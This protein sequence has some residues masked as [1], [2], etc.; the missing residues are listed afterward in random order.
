LN[1]KGFIVGKGFKRC[2][3][4][5]AFVPAEGSDYQKAEAL[6]ILILVTLQKPQTM[7]IIQISQHR[8]AGGEIA[9]GIQMLFQIWQQPQI[10]DIGQKRDGGLGF[11]RIGIRK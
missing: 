6:I 1:Q 8:E 5:F 10:F 3:C 11:E 4:S 2:F 7:G 9:S